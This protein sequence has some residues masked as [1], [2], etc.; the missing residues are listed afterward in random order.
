MW[1]GSVKFNG[2][3]GRTLDSITQLSYTVMHS[4]L[5]DSP[6]PSPYLRVFLTN[7][8][9]V[10]FDATQCA[11]TVPAEDVFNTYEVTDSEQAAAGAPGVARGHRGS[12]WPVD[13]D[14]D[15]GALGYAGASGIAPGV[16]AGFRGP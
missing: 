1:G 11:T 6:I 4:T 7:G 2:L 16:W 15:R 3:N 9:D 13:A 10:V 14:R 5:D 12:S 8:K